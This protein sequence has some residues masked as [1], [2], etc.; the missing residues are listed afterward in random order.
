MFVNVCERRSSNQSEIGI[1]F[2]VSLS[3]DAL[4]LLHRLR[5]RLL[6]KYLIVFNR[7]LRSRWLS[8]QNDMSAPNDFVCNSPSTS[9]AAETAP[10]LMHL[11]IA[12]EAAVNRSVN[13]DI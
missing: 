10:Y 4:L 6:Y 2:V 3:F 1:D 9:M 13:I 11:A 7:Y 5:H 12:T 8:H